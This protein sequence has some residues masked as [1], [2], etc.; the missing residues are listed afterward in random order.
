MAFR[1]GQKVV[2]VHGAFPPDP[3]ECRYDHEIDPV[4]GEVYTVRAIVDCPGGLAGLLLVEIVNQPDYYDG[5]YAEVVFCA[6]CFR[7]VRTTDIG[8]F[9]SLLKSRPL[10]VV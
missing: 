8:V 6:T 10:E 2:H 4:L 7:P 9:R 1:I 5:G 3:P